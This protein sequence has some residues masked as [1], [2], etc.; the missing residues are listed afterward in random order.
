MFDL[1]KKAMGL[2]MQNS[3][4]AGGSPGGSVTANSRVEVAAC[5]ILLEAAYADY[6]CTKDELVHVMRTMKDI[7]RISED[8]AS[9]LLDM[10]HKE[11]DHAVDVYTFTKEINNS[12]SADM[13]LKVIE[14]LWK[15]I[16]SDGVIEKHEDALARKITHLLRLERK[17]ALEAKLRAKQ[18]AEE[19]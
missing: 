4:G 13:K 10:A 5:A 11:R 3:A 15:V 12:F 1:L 8:E 16:Y 9:E 7:F 17:P 2:D 19:R 14:A 6:Q 18:W